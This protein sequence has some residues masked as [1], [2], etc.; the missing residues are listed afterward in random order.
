[1][2]S[3]KLKISPQAPKVSIVG[4]WAPK[5]YKNCFQKVPKNKK[6]QKHEKLCFVYTKHLLREPWVL[7]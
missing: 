5:W 6:D 4:I 1:M 7:P 3:G 2:S